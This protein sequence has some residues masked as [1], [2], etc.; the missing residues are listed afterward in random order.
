[1]QEK[2]DRRNPA[3]RQRARVERLD[4]KRLEEWE[5][6]PKKETKN[7]E[8]R[9]SEGLRSDREKVGGPS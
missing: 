8:G 4:A 3:H 5:G 6:R 7:Q 9:V 1:M 2:R